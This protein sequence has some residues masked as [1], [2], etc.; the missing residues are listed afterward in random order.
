MRS[1]A[2]WLLAAGL[3]CA[4]P[5][6]F[7]AQTAGYHIIK[8]TMLGGIGGWDYVTVDPD[9]HRIYI[10]R[11][12]H[13]IRLDQSGDAHTRHPGSTDPPGLRDDHR[14]GAEARH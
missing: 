9:A 4:L 12:T 10:P 11:A 13:V 1:S 5:Q 8:Q 3:L 6:S 14:L 2:R 7:Q